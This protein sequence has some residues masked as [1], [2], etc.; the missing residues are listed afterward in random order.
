MELTP[1]R[2]VHSVGVQLEER[3]AAAGT[4]LI[5]QTFPLSEEVPQ[6]ELLSPLPERRAWLQPRPNAAIAS[7]RGGYLRRPDIYALHTTYA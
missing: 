6:P 3:P 1:I 4:L 5:H 2:F 7:E